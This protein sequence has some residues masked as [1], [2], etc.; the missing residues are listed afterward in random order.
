MRGENRK[1]PVGFLSWARI[2]DW[3][4]EGAI[5]KGVC[6]PSDRLFF[7]FRPFFKYSLNMPM[8]ERFLKIDSGLGAKVTQLDAVDNG[9]KPPCHLT[10][11]AEV[12][13]TW[14]EA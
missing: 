14:H 6:V 11:E 13:L 12:T 8:I 3:A 4:L 9:V 5:I 2:P 7:V 10:V 1:V